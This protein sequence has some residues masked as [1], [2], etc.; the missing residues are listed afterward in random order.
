M[1]SAALNGFDSLDGVDQWF[2]HALKERFFTNEMA[3][4]EFSDFLD[5]WCPQK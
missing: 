5:G 2:D 1:G 3:I 4:N